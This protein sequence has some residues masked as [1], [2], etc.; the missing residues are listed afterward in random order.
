MTSDVLSRIPLF[1]AFGRDDLAPLLKATTAVSVPAGKFL[2]RR[3]DRGDALYIV[4]TGLLD[5]VIDEGTSSERSLQT[6]FPGDFFGEMSLLTRQPRSAS[7]RALLDSRLIRL[8][9]EQFSGLLE[10]R[11]AIAVHLSRVLSNYLSRTNQSISR[12][13]VRISTVIPVGDGSLASSLAAQLLVSL[14]QQLG[15][16]AAIVFL[17]DHG[18]AETAEPD[19][20]V[21]GRALDYVRPLSS[22]GYYL[23]LGGRVLQ[24]IDDQAIVA[25]V[26]SLRTGYGHVLVWTTPEEALKR[27]SFLARLDQTFIIAC[28][29][30]D[31]DELNVRVRELGNVIK[32]RLRAAFAA[33]AGQRAPFIQPLSPPPLRLIARSDRGVRV[34]E[35]NS[36]A[37][38][39]DEDINRLARALA[40]KTIGLAL[41]SG[42]AQ[43]LAHL[44]VMKAFVEAGI[45]IDF[46]A[47]TSGGALYGAMVASGLPIEDAIRSAVHHTR[48]NLLDKIDFSIPTRGLIRG[49]RIERMIRDSIGDVAFQDLPI[50]LSAVSADLDTGEEVVINEGPVYQGVRASISV[51]GIFEPYL[52][53]GRLLIDG[54]VVN[55]LPVSVA[56]SMGADIVIAVQVPAPGKVAMEA[57]ARA[58]NH[59][60]KADYNIVS[61]IVRSH[62]F[63]GDMLA[64]KA[65][66]EADVLIKP[67]VARFGWREYRSAPDIID[68]GFQAGWQALTRISA[69]RTVSKLR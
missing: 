67:D 52:L 29:P 64:N 30:C 53:N 31:A 66:S 13:G 25:I 26:N 58:G 2:F 65:A 34:S 32:G 19:S 7:I 47:G 60:R 1:A 59:R 46:I 36:T 39:V 69:R 57:Q 23:R 48:R 3:G 10:E 9:E 54:V 56:R 51:P 50:P 16:P 27:L 18:P 17:G 40:G 21:P 8:S 24:G 62:H 28:H 22:G 55:P 35:A 42:T 38:F 11:P 63:V 6:F 68:A 43:G 37:P 33:P 20:F 4:E 61:T 15:L 12:Q 41:G 49:R 44:G 45:P 5:A 14:E